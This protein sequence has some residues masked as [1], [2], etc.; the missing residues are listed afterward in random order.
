MVPEHRA[1]GALS[2]GVGPA[3]SDSL[4]LFPG[5]LVDLHR[6]FPCPVPILPVLLHAGDPVLLAGL[7][8]PV[9]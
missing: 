5:I 3:T 6:S 9:V 1:W 4:M 8:I 2:T 7:D